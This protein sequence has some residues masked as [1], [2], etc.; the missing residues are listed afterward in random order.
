MT[1]L[2]EVGK[3][4]SANAPRPLVIEI[5][6]RAIKLEP[7]QEN[8][9]G[10]LELFFAQVDKTGRIVSSASRKVPLKLTAADR[11]QLLQ[12]GLV[13]NVPVAIKGDCEHLRVALRDLKS[14]A[15]GTVTVPIR[16]LR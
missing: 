13:L 3:A 5:D 2:I 15:I 9:S 8:W 7:V 14:G 12:D 10:N 16:N 11:K 4:A 6:T 1:F